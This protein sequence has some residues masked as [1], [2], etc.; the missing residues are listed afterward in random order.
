MRK[1]ETKILYP[2]LRKIKNQLNW[3]PKT[4]LNVGLRKT[5]NYIKKIN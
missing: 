3:K 2:D 1:Q 5:I 4:T